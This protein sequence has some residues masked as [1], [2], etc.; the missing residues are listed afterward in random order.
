MMLADQLTPGGTAVDAFGRLRVSE[1]YTIFDSTFRYSDDTRNW[2]IALTGSGTSTHNANTS[3]I[4]MTTSTAS[5]DKVIRQTKRY[6]LYQPGK[7]LLSLNT[8][9]MQPKINVRQRVGYFDARNGF[10]LEHDGETAYI[11]KRSYVSGSVVDTPIAQANWSEDKFDGTGY[12]KVTLDFTKSQILWMDIEWLGVGSARVGFVIN[13]KFY[14]AH[15]FHHANIIVSTYMTTASLP[16][17]YEIE[18]TGTAASS[19]TLRHICNSLISEGG[20]SPKVST[21]SITTTLTGIELSNTEF[22]P[23]I[24]IRL[25]TTNFGGVVV[26]VL[27]D[28]FGLQTTPFNFKLLSDAT[29]T[30][31]TWTSAGTES[32]IEYNITATAVSGGRN[33]MQ[34]IFTGG[35]SAT[36]TKVSFKE[37][38]SSYQL[39]TRIDGTSETFVIA[40][41]ATTNNDD[42]V[43]SLIWEEFN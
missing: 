3:S 25:K 31:G 11:V 38:N 43:C 14:T 36:P 1:P 19:T 27:T 12:S 34:G 2:D 9:T 4:A 17:R 30:G 41:Q 42:A 24:A 7:S 10:F 13:G 32:H 15:I 33:Y 20:Y 16:I 5:G 23:M 35:T 39:R 37:F 8:F 29:V 28:L 21:R 22:R 18:N 6:F 26:P 40:A